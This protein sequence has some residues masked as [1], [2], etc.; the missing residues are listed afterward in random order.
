MR[1]DRFTLSL[2]HSC[3]AIATASDVFNS[4]SHLEQSTSTSACAPA[5]KTLYL[6]LPQLL[7]LDDWCFP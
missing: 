6:V 5:D 2:S 4:S 3:P 7:M 1:I